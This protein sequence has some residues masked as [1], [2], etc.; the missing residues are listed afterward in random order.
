[1]KIETN[2]LIP[3]HNILRNPDSA[4]FFIKNISILEQSLLS[5]DKIEILSVEDKLYVHNG[6]HRL[7]AFDLI[8]GWIDSQFL[9]IYTYTLDEMMSVN[10]KIGWITP[11]DP[12]YYVREHDFH[13]YKRDLKLYLDNDNKVEF[14]KLLTKVV[15]PRKVFTLEQ[16]WGASWK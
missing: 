11:Y 14:E 3:T 1:M 2:N 6:H 10:T 4:L 8:Y 7:V 12:E 9:N 5:S 15:L 16:L 13:K